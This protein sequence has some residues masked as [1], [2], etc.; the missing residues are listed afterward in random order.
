MAIL[1]PHMALA[2]KVK[3]LL[4]V[5]LIIGTTLASIFGWVHVPPIMAIGDILV[6]VGAA[7]ALFGVTRGK[8]E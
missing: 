4:G 7:L 6:I 1:K 2:G 5:F 3:I 8:V